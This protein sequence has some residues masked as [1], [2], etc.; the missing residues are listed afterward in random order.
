MIVLVLL[1]MTGLMATVGGI[2]I[3]KDRQ[4][5]QA[6]ADVH[7]QLIGVDQRLFTLQQAEEAEVEAE[8]S[9]FFEDLFRESNFDPIGSLRSGFIG[10]LTA[11]NRNMPSYFLTQVTRPDTQESN[12]DF[13]LP[14]RQRE[15]ILQRIIRS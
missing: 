14:P 7:T 10:S 3:F 11:P 4:Q 2:V 9:V 5:A 1:G 13:V 8:T 6:L 12:D 15:L